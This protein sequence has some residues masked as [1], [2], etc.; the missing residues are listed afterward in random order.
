MGCRILGV[1]SAVPQR[2]ISNE[3]LAGIMD[4]SDEWIAT[5]TGIR[6]RRVLSGDE[7]MTS[8]SVEA[9]RR[10]LSMAG[11]EPGEVDL[12]IMC[13][14][15][16]DDIFG[17]ACLV[18]REL[19][20]RGAVAFDITAACSGFVLGLVTASRFING[21]G[22]R[23]VLVVGADALSRFVDWSDRATCILF[24]DGAGAALVQAA[25]HGTPSSLLGFD[26]G[27][28]GEGA[29]H[30]NAHVV[31]CSA[32]WHTAAAAASSPAT[33]TPSA[34][35]LNGHP[36]PS[37]RP[38]AEAP[39]AQAAPVALAVA[40]AAGAPSA[41]GAATLAHAGAEQGGAAAE[42]QERQGGHAEV[43][44]PPARA[45]PKPISMNG[46][47]VYKFAV[48]AVPQVLN[49]AMEEA[50]VHVDDLDWLL[51]H[52]ANQRIL[53]AAAQKLGIP[54]EKVISNVANYGNTSAASI[55]LALDEA[56]RSGKVKAGDLVAVAGFGAG[57][58]WAGAV[59]RWG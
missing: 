52:Q 49:K 6:N 54:A 45:Q 53:D 12:I 36:S 48:T 46:R 11:V 57:L 59:V 55:P 13:T 20:C 39:S 21:G 23:N 50:G 30:L 19:G 32:P 25:P 31:A 34:T 56:V 9:C 42:Q 18:Q 58:T 15:S 41:N 37:S 1:G 47:E 8:L 38:G 17:G 22:F 16:P 24:G 2:V 10:A 44:S 35:P 27:S 33:S 7:S 4:T 26:M 29:R 43:W 51:L 28:D 14:S 3:V 5:R 40:E